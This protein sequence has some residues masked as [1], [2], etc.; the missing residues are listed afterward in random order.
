LLR[1]VVLA[2]V[3]FQRFERGEPVSMESLSAIAAAIGTSPSRSTALPGV[4]EI[5]AS[6][7][8]RRVTPLCV[9]SEIDQTLQADLLRAPGSSL[10]PISRAALGQPLLHPLADRWHCPWAMH[11]ARCDL[12]VVG[13]PADPH[14]CWLLTHAGSPLE[15][16]A[17]VA[18]QVGDLASGLTASQFICLSLYH[19]IKTPLH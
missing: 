6:P 3:R 12:H 7:L 14:D 17:M 4:G 15:V 11:L 9:L 10:A 19:G 1:S 18:N 16:S 13:Q 2:C 5:D 8:I